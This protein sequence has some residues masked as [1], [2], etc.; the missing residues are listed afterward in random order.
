[1]IFIV[2][3]DICEQLNTNVAN[4][5]LSVQVRKEQIAEAK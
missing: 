1:M 3:S 5:K 4:K 2:E